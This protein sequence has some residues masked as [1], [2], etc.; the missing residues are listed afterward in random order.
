MEAI[1]NTSEGMEKLLLQVLT[2]VDNTGVYE[3]DNAYGIL[4]FY[5]SARAFN[6]TIVKFLQKLNLL[7]FAT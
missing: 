7:P 1:V 5:V 3:F 4:F 2:H 6:T